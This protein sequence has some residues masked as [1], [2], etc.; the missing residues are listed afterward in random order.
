M[1]EPPP[2]Q[3]LC[4]FGV[5]DRP[6]RLRGGTF[7]QLISNTAFGFLPL[8]PRSLSQIPA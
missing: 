7:R 6:Q 3:V 8:S 1:N 2:Y 5:E 4:A